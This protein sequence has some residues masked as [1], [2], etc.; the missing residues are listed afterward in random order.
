MTDGDHRP[1][2]P[3]LMTVPSPTMV[4]AGRTIG[5]P[6]LSPDGT[7]VVVHVR[8]GAGPRLVCIE[9]GDGERVA[10]G[11]ETVIVFDPS[12]VGSHPFG[13]GAWN[14]F[15]DSG[16]VV[17]VAADGLYRTSRNGGPGQLLATPP[18]GTWFASPTVSKDG[19]RIAVIVENDDS[20]SVAVV[21]LER[22]GAVEIVVPGE[23]G[24]FCM[25]PAWSSDGA[26]SWHQWEAPA[27]PWDFATIVTRRVDGSVRILADGAPAQPQ[28]SPDG[29][30]LGHVAD[31]ANG[32][33]NVCVDGHAVVGRGAGESY[34]HGTPSWGPGQRS[35]CWSPGGSQVAFVRNEAGFARLGVA[36]V[37]TGA[38]TELAKAWHIGLSWSRSPGGHERIAA[39]RT[40]GVTPPQLVVYDLATHPVRTT[41]ARGPVGGW[42]SVGLPEPE[43]S[44]WSAA[45]GTTVHG[46][47]Y[48]A[49]RP[50][51][52]T[53]VSL[54]GGPTDQT[55]V[56]FNPR[57][58][59]WLARG[60]SVFVPDHRGSTGWGHGYQQAMNE[61]WG[62]LDVSDCADGLRALAHVGRVVPER[63]V[64]IG[65]SAGG[66]CALHLLLRHPELFSCGV[67][68]Y[69]V[70]DLAD[71][72]ATT[73]RFERHYNR[74]L[75][76]PVERYGERSPITAAATLARPLLLLHGDSDPVVSVAQSRRFAAAATTAGATVELVVYEGE[77][78]S[79]KRSATTVDELLRIDTFLA[80]FCPTD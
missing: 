64:V 3:D 71:L 49:P 35:W 57:F 73:H 51:G 6:R 52:G 60:W 62:E 55:T 68:L 58:G 36:D 56:T 33:R 26:L 48:P 38:V 69:P 43:V 50:H 63:T 32:W 37:T 21:D 78:H 42:E 80:R 29:M 2:E 28:W 13:G 25:D 14:W 47:F 79:W 11:P 67:A 30:R 74:M 17:Y 66:F 27:M 5:D 46:R 45:D 1:D 15:P 4:V 18:D 65:G 23:P 16:S 7:A 9:L 10:P 12:V 61:R 34:E 24:V 19:C 44:H 39:I 41:I 20:Q 77:V 76:G 70:T 72:D 8:D 31:A 53:I 22:D 40:G 75:V 59:Y 54:H